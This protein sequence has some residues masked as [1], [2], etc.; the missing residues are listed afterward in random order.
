M[1]TD[2]R[3]SARLIQ[4]GDGVILAAALLL[5]LTAML[6]LWLPGPAG[7]TVTVLVGEQVYGVYPL[8]SNAVV[9][10]GHNRIV[11]RDGGLSG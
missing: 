11:I 5:T 7:E 6:A 2:R 10:T 9:D 4:R 8:S 1:S 3:S